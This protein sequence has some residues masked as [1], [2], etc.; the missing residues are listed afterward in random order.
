MT[1]VKRSPGING[2]KVNYSCTYANLLK[3]LF[4]KKEAK[5]ILLDFPSLL[6][7]FLVLT[8]YCSRCQYQLDNFDEILQTKAYFGK[9]MKEKC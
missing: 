2:F 8:Y 9:Y 4:I 7:S 6:G 5:I 3:W 1:L